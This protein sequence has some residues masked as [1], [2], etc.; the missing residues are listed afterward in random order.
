M[1]SYTLLDAVTATGVGPTVSLQGAEGGRDELLVQVDITGTSGTVQIY[2][3]I[4][5]LLPFALLTTIT[6]S[7]LYPL[8]RVGE[9]YANVSAISAATIK[10]AVAL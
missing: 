4:S 2:G 8:A 9:I 6:A 7:G 1:H 10:A 3:R 5:S